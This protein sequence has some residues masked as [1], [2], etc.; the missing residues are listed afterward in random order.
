[1]MTDRPKSTIRNPGLA[2]TLVE[3]LVVIAIIGILIALLLPA[4][5]SAREAARN[6]Q[7]K[8]NVKQI[9]LALHNYHTAL[10]SFPPGAVYN[11]CAY[12]QGHSW[13]AML[14]PYLE[15]QA[16]HDHL[17]FTRL[18]NQSPNTEVL[19]DLLI[20]NLV[21]PSDPD[22][23]LLDNG[24]LSSGGYLPGPA[25]T[26]SMGQSYAPSGGPVRMNDCPYGTMSPNINCID[27]SAPPCSGGAGRANQGSPGMFAGGY[28]AYRIDDC[29]D[30]TT[31]TLLLGEQLPVYGVH[32]MYFHSH[33]N[34]GT[35][36][37]PPN[38]W[39]INPR[40][41]PPAPTGE[42]V[43]RCFADMSGFNSMHGGGVNMALVDGSVRFISDTIDYTVWQYLGMRHSGQPIDGSKF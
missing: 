31:N 5:Q 20:P 17:D 27:T 33:L 36:H 40:N 28:R 9:A 6:L 10:R 43:S 15:Q 24:R 42:V 13:I 1:M 32:M 16:V 37:L 21:C 3:L 19:V 18:P 35:T 11:G 8:N 22:G 30:G 29:R 38:Y 23:G 4:V 14:L 7:C 2:F 25:G 12:R 41:C 34:T 39:K 26:F